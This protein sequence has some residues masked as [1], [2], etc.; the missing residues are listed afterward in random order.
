MNRGDVHNFAS[1]EQFRQAARIM[2]VLVYELHKLY[3]KLL[4]VMNRF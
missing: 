1:Y 4:K 3:P 2:P